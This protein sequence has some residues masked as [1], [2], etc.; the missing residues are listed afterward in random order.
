[1]TATAGTSAPP[2]ARTAQAPAVRRPRRVAVLP[3]TALVLGALYCI[4]PTLWILVA[5]TKSRTKLFSTDTYTPSFDLGIVRNIRD[6]SHYQGGIFWHWMLNSFFYAAVGGLLAS[7]VSAATGYAL[8]KY[9]FRGRSAL[10]N[11]ILAGVL[12]PQI[13]LAVPQYLLLSKVGLTD[14][15]IG[16]LLPQLFNPY[17]IYLCKIYAQSAVPDSLLEAGR[18]DGAGEGRLFLSVGLRLMGPGLV[19]VFLLQFI[20][21]WNNFL[22]PYVMLTSDDKFPLT[23]GLYS[24]LRHGA[25]EA[26]LYSLVITGTLLSVLPVIALF[27]SLQRFWRIDLVTGAL[28]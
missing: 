9:E 4:V 5:A 26:S 19:T 25:A 17:G 1:M 6:L 14:S 16:V 15:L 3:T 18:I 21:I 13:V 12:L 2:R 8:A 24:L 11:T 20:A 27:L 7:F 28:K 23:V 22:L 10:F